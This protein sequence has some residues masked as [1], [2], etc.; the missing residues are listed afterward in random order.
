MKTILIVEDTADL[1]MNLADFLRMEGFHVIG[2]A[3]GKSAVE[4][5]GTEMPDAMITDLSM[6]DMDGFELIRI[7]RQDLN[8]K[9]LPIAIF[10]AR[11]KEENLTRAKSF[12][13]SLY[14]TKPCEPEKLVGYI[15]SII[16]PMR[17]EEN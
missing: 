17:H 8:L 12:G 7:V 1:L 16:N 9:S 3:T 4:Y 15:Q 6:P 10:S 11:P 5:L 2:V 13:V 14:I